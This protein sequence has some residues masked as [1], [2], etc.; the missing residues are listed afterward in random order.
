MVLNLKSLKII[1]G[2]VPII[3]LKRKKY[4]WKKFA[5]KTITIT[6]EVTIMTYVQLQH[7]AC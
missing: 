5:E 1:K 3:L 2:I 7:F 6:S 4:G